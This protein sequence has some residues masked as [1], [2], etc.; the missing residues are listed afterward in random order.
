A[1]LV[2]T[3][4]IQ[5][6]APGTFVYVVDPQHVVALRPVKLGPTTGDRVAVQSGVNPGDQIVVDGADKLKDGAKVTLGRQGTPADGRPPQ[7][8]TRQPDDRRR[9]RKGDSP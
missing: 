5:R 7:A 1:N 3:A 8:P 6:G 4:A 9:A 2:P